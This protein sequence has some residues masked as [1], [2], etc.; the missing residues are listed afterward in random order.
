MQD[1]QAQCPVGKGKGSACPLLVQR[2]LQGGIDGVPDEAG[3]AGSHSPLQLQSHHGKPLFDQALKQ[4]SVQ[5]IPL[6]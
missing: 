5:I 3:D 1:V 6:P 4:G 2:H